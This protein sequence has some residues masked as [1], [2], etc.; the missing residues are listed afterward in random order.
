M[1]IKSVVL[2]LVF[3]ASLLPASAV[4]AEEKLPRSLEDALALLYISDALLLPEAEV[5]DSAAGAGVQSLR[6]G[7]ERVSDA[8][9]LLARMIHAAKQE[10]N[11]LDANCRVLRSR[12]QAGGDQAAVR[13]LDAYCKQQRQRL[14]N[15]IGLLHKLR[16]DRR[17]TLTRWWHSFK[18]SGAHLWRRIG[19]TGRNILRRVGPE[20][21]NVV[22]GGGTL[23]G[24]MLKRLVKQAVKGLARER[25]RQA[26]VH[27]VERL[28]QGQLEIVRESGVLKNDEDDHDLQEG[29]VD[30]HTEAGDALPPAQEL[31]E[32]QEEQESSCPGDSSWVVPYWEDVIQPQLVAE[33]RACQRTAIAI[34]KACLQDQG[35]QGVCPEEALEFCQPKYRAIPREETSGAVTAALIV[36][37]SEA[38]SVSGTL[39]Y[40]GS[41]GPVR[42]Q[43]HYQLKDRHLCTIT[44]SST[45]VGN[46][47][48]DNCS[49]NGTAQVSEVYDGAACASVC[50]SSP[51]GEV[52]CPV[53]RTAAV[54]WWATLED[55]ELRGGVDGSGSQVSGFGFGSE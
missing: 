7:V 6:P 46:F 15:R 45:F 8:D 51:D 43:V 35:I 49:L 30:Q 47:D 54:P 33:G 24:G 38:E 20:A 25:L 12:Y 16:G 32:S 10:R 34:Y 19:P 41:G 36:M 13:K 26:A 4:Q 55:G 52:A 3:W 44:V 29:D 28:L 21:L 18:R 11:D 48:L 23:D 27:G 5:D 1:R 22:A 42:G 40:N 14:S 37:H 53:T 9:P 17:K 39:V 31:P 2:L 50:S